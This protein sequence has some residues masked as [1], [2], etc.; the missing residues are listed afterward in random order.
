MFMSDDARWEPNGDYD[1]EYEDQFDQ[2]PREIECKYCQALGL[3]WSKQ[4]QGWRL[5]DKEGNLHSCMI[6]KLKAKREI[7]FTGELK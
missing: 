1:P 4:E 6:N 3:Y 5:V 7:D 2:D